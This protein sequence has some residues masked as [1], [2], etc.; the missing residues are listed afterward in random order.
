M[1]SLHGECPASAAGRGHSSARDIGAL[2]RRHG[3]AFRRG[4]ALGAIERRALRDISVCRTGALGGRRDVCANC[5]CE[6]EVWNSCRNRHCPKCQALRQARWVSARMQR[7][8]PVPHFHVVFTLPAE[9]R[10]LVRFYEGPFLDLLFAAA[11]ESLLQLAGDSRRLGGL[12]GVTA[13]V[14]TWGRNLTFHPH[15]HCIVTAGGLD[16]QQGWT[17][18]SE[19]YLLPVQVLGELFRGK[20]LD[21]LARLFDAGKLEVTPRV[22]ARVAEL[23]EP[24]GFAALKRALYEKAWRVYT[25]APF[26]KPD[27]LFRYLGL[28]TH[29][30]AIS[31]HRLLHVDDDQVVFRTRDR[32]ICRLAPVEFIRRFLLHVLPFGF[33]KIRHFGLYA[34]GNVNSKL[35]AARVAIE[36]QSADRDHARPASVVPHQDQALP[37]DWH[38]LF[39]QLTG[40]DL[41]ACPNCGARLSATPMPN[42]ASP[43]R[44]PPCLPP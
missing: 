43:A 10:E 34:A 17:D 15:L 20:F 40:I 25:K 14:H 22:P 8:L 29:R 28:Y 9:L 44:A 30:V 36:Q 27:A 12:L 24:A 38:A 35:A 32:K 5:G 11:S 23:L 3:D 7:A 1:P 37:E 13:V 2:F 31:N 16:Q 42:L 6:R 26:Q 18:S 41:G 19:R 33:V 4:H 39:H 21:G